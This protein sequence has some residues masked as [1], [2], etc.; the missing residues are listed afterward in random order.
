M[1]FKHMVTEEVVEFTAEDVIAFTADDIKLWE[2][3]DEEA[4]ETMSDI[5]ILNEG[6]VSEIVDRFW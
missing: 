6:N 4:K 1:K 2:P 5:Q 3:L